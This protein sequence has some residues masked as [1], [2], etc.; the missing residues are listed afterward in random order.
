M[1]TIMKTVN[2]E[3]YK[4]GMFFGYKLVNTTNGKWY[5]GISKQTPENYTTSS[6]STELLS[7]ISKGEIERIIEIVDDSWPNLITWEHQLLTEKNAAGDTMSYNGNNGM[8]TV[9]K[10]LNSKLMKKVANDIINDNRVSGIEPVDVDL[11][12]EVLPNDK[13]KLK[14][15][16]R[17]N[18]YKVWQV[19][20]VFVDTEHKG[21]ITSMGTLMP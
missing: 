14:P 7:A 16:S 19:R 1:K 5:Y 21:D 13:T 12:D 3:K 9:K 20:D 4:H 18:S 11:T 8:S 15:S 2:M 6:K 10:C 17:F